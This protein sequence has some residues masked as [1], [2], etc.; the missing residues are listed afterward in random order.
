MP[1]SV[2]AITTSP[3][4]H[5]N[6]ESALDT[7]LESF[8][9]MTIEKVVLNDLNISPCKGCGRCEKIGE[10]IQKDDYQALAEK[11]R[12]CD[13]LIFA[14]PVYSMSVCAQ[15]KIL[16]DRCQ[17]FWSR[18]YILKN[19]PKVEGKKYGMFISTAG[20]LSEK[21]FEHTVPVAR[22]LFDVSEISARRTHLLLL[23]G[24]DA[25]NDFKNSPEAIQKAKDAGDTFRKFLEN[26]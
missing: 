3:R 18:K 23:N 22:F 24:L 15:A 25:K 12:A 7:V 17:V 10:C 16:I 1:L 2:L 11:I 19:L 9:G 21:V 5:G 14:S 13:V 4:R 6:S 8:S 20:Q 26:Q